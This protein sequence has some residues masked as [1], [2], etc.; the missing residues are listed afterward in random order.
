M[1]IIS[2][3]PTRSRWISLIKRAAI[4]AILGLSVWT[5]YS[6]PEAGTVRFPGKKPAIDPS[7]VSY[8]RSNETAARITEVFGANV[9]IAWLRADD[10]KGVTDPKRSTKPDPE[11][12]RFTPAS[13]ADSTDIVEPHAYFDGGGKDLDSEMFGSWFDRHGAFAIWVLDTADGVER[14]LVSRG[15]LFSPL[16]TPDGKQVIYTRETEVAQRVQSAVWQRPWNGGEEEKLADGSGLWIA[17]DPQTHERWLYGTDQFTELWRMSLATRS[18]QV[19]YTGPLSRRLSITP[20]LSHACGEFPW[21]QIGL[22][23]LTTGVLDDSRFR[24]GCNA[25]VAP[26]GSGM[27]SILNGG[28]TGVTVVDPQGGTKD[29]GLLPPLMRRTQAGLRGNI[30]NPKWAID[31]H[32]IILSGPVGS[33]SCDAA[34][35]WIGVYSN[36]R[37][38]ITSW[39][40]V[41]DSDSYDAQPFIWR[42]PTR[43]R[44]SEMVASSP[45]MDRS[46]PARAPA[47]WSTRPGLLASW[48]GG[49]DRSGT[50]ETRMTLKLSGWARF[51]QHRDL[52]MNGG[53]Y[54]ARMPKPVS[55]TGASV[56]STLGVEMV[57]RFLRTSLP[58]ADSAVLADLRDLIPPEQV[59]RLVVD[60]SGSL[61]LEVA[62]GVLHRFVLAQITDDQFHHVSIGYT[63]G[64]VFALLDG[65]P[66]LPE[67]HIGLLQFTS[68]GQT[69]IG[70]QW[71]GVLAALR[72]TDGVPKT[73]L[74]AEDLRYFRTELKKRPVAARRTV[75]AIPVSRSRVPHPASILPYRSA[76]VVDTYRLVRGEKDLITGATCHVAH[77]RIMD[78]QAV[79]LMRAKKDD[80]EVELTLEVLS[81]HPELESIF[82]VDTV[83]H[84]A[85]E[86]IWVEADR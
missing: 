68:K 20:D 72:L 70:G 74:V 69:V 66:C 14:E 54:E 75:R 29:V 27:V 85:G 37:S 19:L 10:W 7:A 52:L 55:A 86:R 2:N 48:N 60:K 6:W 35:L 50:P 71:R 53:Q 24:P 8:L 78:G 76:L 79:P 57:F 25:H 80:G 39:I 44:A 3:P 84:P 15:R 13:G 73:D 40:Q 31:S 4:V 63:E 47:P 41:T 38:V 11:R 21:P 45:K 12:F 28:H 51:D 49:V 64:S 22:L 43:A 65:I 58:P 26:D 33:T 30:W 61:V 17:D 81:V 62:H 1:D 83:D 67:K 9:R 18:R 82:L 46:V 23:D 36:D 5:W 34:D 77:F 56:R 32:H 16:I 42:A 59:F